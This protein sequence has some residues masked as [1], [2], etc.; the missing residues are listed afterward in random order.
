MMRWVP[1]GTNVLETGEKKYIPIFPLWPR[2]VGRTLNTRGERRWL[3]FALIERV[4]TSRK[5]FTESWYDMVNLTFSQKIKALG[6]ALGKLLIF[7]LALSAIQAL[8]GSI[9]SL[10]GGN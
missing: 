5:T 9:W 4:A 8:S 3:E 2:E 6:T 7:M 10:L 1:K